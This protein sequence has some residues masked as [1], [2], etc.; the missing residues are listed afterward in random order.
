MTGYR[1]KV[2]TC[3]TMYRSRQ[4][5]QSRLNRYSNTTPGNG[6][7]KCTGHFKYSPNRQNGHADQSAGSFPISTPQN[8]KYNTNTHYLLYIY[9]HKA[10]N[11]FVHVT[12]GKQ[13]VLAMICF[14]SAYV[15]Y[16]DTNINYGQS[17][18]C[19]CEIPLTSKQ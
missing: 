14:H 13:S 16:T 8:Q 18:C 1:D 5:D 3:F 2:H 4:N 17:K 12:L 10:S 15:L 6:N 11:I 9:D 19:T 7:N